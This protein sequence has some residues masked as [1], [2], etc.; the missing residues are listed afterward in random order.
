MGAQMVIEKDGQA[1]DQGDLLSVWLVPDEPMRSA[2]QS[3]IL[4]ASRMSGTHRF[5]PHITVL[6]DVKATL[7]ELETIAAGIARSETPLNLTLAGPVVGH[8]YF[9]SFYAPVNLNP[10]LTALHDA[11]GAQL[12]SKLPDAP[13]RPHVSLAYGDLQIHHRDRL[14]TK[15]EDLLPAICHFSKLSLVL[16]NQS[17]PIEDWQVLKE[18]SL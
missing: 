4:D 16:S 18:I 17:L 1:F 8:S 9:Q 11:F 14:R 12:D 3:L 5:V 2:L 10:R 6:G 13:F 15:A 7:A